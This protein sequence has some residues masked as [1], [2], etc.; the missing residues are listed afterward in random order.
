MMVNYT[1]YFIFIL[2]FSCAHHRSGQYVLVKGKWTF[3]KSNIGFL[4]NGINFGRID[5]GRYGNIDDSKFIWPIPSSKKVSSYFGVRKG[6]HHDGVDIPAISGTHIVASAGGKVISAGKMKGYGKVIVL[7]HSGG[8]HT[9]YAHN[10]K[11]YVKKGQHVSQGEVI[12]K[13]GSTGRSTGPHLH[14]EIRRNNRVRNPALYLA[15]LG[16]YYAKN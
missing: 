3:K 2:L 11:H 4:K 16:K 7:S 10:S 6:K 8:Y 12:G 5:N 13:V 15:R 1:K 14:F 9:I